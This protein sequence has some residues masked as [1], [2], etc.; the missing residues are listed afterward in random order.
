M[1]IA[2]S[3]RPLHPRR[4]RRCSFQVE[5]LED[6]CLLSGGLE[7]SLD[8]ALWH[9]LV[10]DTDQPSAMTGRANPELQAHRSSPA[11][12]RTNSAGGP[13]AAQV[14]ALYRTFLHQKPS[15]AQL[16]QGVAL[17]K[18]D[19]L[20]QLEAQIL[21]SP[22]YFSKRAH[23]KNARF[24][25][26]V[27]QDVLGHALDATHLQQYSTMLAHGASRT[28]VAT[29]ILQLK[30][31]PPQGVTI[32]ID[33]LS[34]GLVTNQNFT[35][36]GHLLGN[37][38]AVNFLSFTTTNAGGQT[39]NPGS[40]PFDS[41]G[42]FHFTTM[43]N[44]VSGSVDQGSQT[45]HV[46]AYDPSSNLIATSVPFPFTFDTQ[47]PQL[48]IQSPA[49]LLTTNTNVAVTG[50]VTDVHSGLAGLQAQ[51]DSGSF[52]NV[53]FDA[54]GNFSFATAL[55]LDGSADGGHTVHLVAADQAGNTSGSDR[56]F[57]LDTLNP[58]VGM[59]PLDLSVATTVGAATQFLYTG[60]DPVQKGVAPGIIDPIRAA[61]LRG[62]VLTRDGT[63]LA[64]VTV[65]VVSHS[66]F[67]ST[68]TRR[69]GMFDMAV[70]GGGLLTVNY[71]RDGS[72]PAQRQVQVPWEDYAWLP[73]VVLIPVDSHFTMIDLSA[74]TPIQVAR[75]SA[76]SDADGTRQATLLFPQ[77][78]QATM[79]LADGTTQPLT[80]L[81]VRATEYTVGATGPDAMPAALPPTSGYTYAVEFS[82]DEAAAAGATN[83]GFD[84]P[85]VSYVDNFLGFPVGGAV[86][87]GYYDRSQSQWVPSQ[88]GRV[89]KILS[90]TGGRADVDVEGS[91]QAAGA[92]TLAALGITDAE[93]QSLAG[94][95]QPGQSLWRVP[96]THFTP[97]DYNWPYGLPDDATPPDQPDPQP[98]RP[99]DNPYKR[100]GCIIGV[101]NQSL[102]ENVGIAGTP[103]GLNY[104]SDRAPGHTAAYTLK[105]PLSGANVPGTLR[106]IHLEIEVAGRRI[107]ENFP[108]QPNQTHTFTWDGKDAY[109]RSLQGAQPIR[110]AV[111]YEYR[112]Q[113]FALAGAAAASFGRA[114]GGGGG[115]G[116]AAEFVAFRNA[117]EIGIRQGWQGLIGAWDSQPQ[118]LGGWGLDV[119]HAYDL[120]GQV[121]YLGDGTRRS[122]EALAPVIT[123]VAGGGSSSDDGGLATQAK[124]S[125]LVGVALGPDGSLYIAGNDDHRV[126]R[127]GP[128]GII[129][130][131]AG[132]GSGGFSG[133]GGPATQAQ[134]AQ[135][136]GV[137]VGPDGSLYISD[138]LSH[139]IRRVGPDGII[140]TVAGNSP[141]PNIFGYSGDGGPATEALLNFPQGVAVGPDNSLYIADFG[142]GVVRRVGPDGII[143]TVAGNG[144]RSDSGDGG[145]ATQA[146]VARPFGVA[147]GADSSLY[148]TTEFHRVRRVGP[149]GIITTVAGDGSSGFSGDGFQ[150]TQAQLFGPVGIAVGPDGSLYVDDSGNGRIR[151]VG[152]DGIITTVAGNGTSAFGGDGGP[153]T[154]APLSNSQGVAVGPDNNLYVGETGNGRVRRVAPALPG[155]SVNDLV[156]PAEDGSELYVFTTSGRHQRTL[157]ALTGA[158][159][160]QFAYDGAGR[161]TQVT[162]A[163][164]NTTTV[165]RD[166][167][168][169]PTAIV[170]PGG[171]RTVLTLDANG[172]LTG[173]TDPAGEATHLVSGAGGLLTTF[174]DARG[175]GRHFGYDDQGRLTRDEDPVDGVKILTRTEQA[176]GYTVAVT[177]GLGMTSTHQVE[178]LATGDQRR[179]DTMADGT[180]STELIRKDG[181]RT[182]TLADGTV[183]QVKL[184]PDPRFGMADPIISSL[185]LTTPGG[186]VSTL[187]QTRTVT[188]SDPNNPLSLTS[189]TD[190]FVVNGAT[191][192]S[193][194][195]AAARTITSR[196]PQE[197]NQ[198]TILDEKGHVASTQVPGVDPVQF[199]YDTHGHL[200]TV[201]Q[202]MRTETLTYNPQGNLVSMTDPLSQTV[203]FAYDL[204]GRVT[205]QTLPDGRQIQFSYDANGN[206]AT[207]TPPG[208]P[209]HAFTYTPV[210]LTQDYTPPDVGTGLTGTHYTYN[211][212]RQ[213]IQVT[214]PDGT[215]VGFGYDSGGN[216]STITE[217]E[218]TETLT[219]DPQTGNLKTMTAPSGEAMAYDYD[220]GLLTGT[221]WS[222]PVSGSVQHTLDAN[223]QV[224][225]ES[226]TGFDPVSF[227][228][229]RDG[230]LTRAGALTLSHDAQNGRLTGS[231]LSNV[232]D[233]LS[234]D[235]FGEVTGYQ[236]TVSGTS[237]FSIQD[238]PDDLGRVSQR[239]E[240]MG[241]VT[242]TYAYTYDPAG[243][244]TAVTKDG[245]LLSQYGY[246]AN[247]NRLSYTGP[248]GT[249]NGTYDSQDRLLQYGTDTYAYRAS[250]ELKSKTDTATN[251][252]TN[253]TYDP[254]GNLLAVTLPDGTHLDYVVDGQN[255]RIGKK[256]NGTLVQCF[257]YDG[258]HL[259]AELDGAGNVVGRFIYGSRSNVPDYMIKGGTTYRIIADQLGS[260]RLV[261]NTTTGQ[262]VQRMDYDEFGN[263]TNETNPGFQPFG[264]A[265]GLYARDTI[266]VR[267]GARDYDAETGRW[268]GKDPIGFAGG[269]A[270][271]YRYA[272]GDPVNSIDFTGLDTISVG[273]GVSYTLIGLAGSGFG[274][275]VVDTSGQVALYYGSGGGTALGAGAAGGVSV[276]WSNGQTYK[277]FGGPFVNGSLSGGLGPSASLDYFADPNN[278]VSGFGLTVGPGVGGGASLLITDTEVIPLFDIGFLGDWAYDAL[279]PDE[280]PS[281][282]S[283]DLCP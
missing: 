194:F 75:G 269:D 161:L 175:A 184:G 180:K 208:R 143:T 223:F 245:A 7:L 141:A 224:V 60:S 72:L 26:A 162:D 128:D 187:S 87:A 209:A 258:A 166:A 192:T 281:R 122:A 270:N 215:T 80:T 213:L 142:N 65:T 277:D 74:S 242:H 123:T 119:Q 239:T 197:R 96:I 259:V 49:S 138:H 229:D 225:S 8:G 89:I 145:L 253:Y 232:T 262:V 111:S 13:Q 15:A 99:L 249:L 199:T 148:I 228:Y 167:D 263:V 34:P 43:L 230:L 157:D 90:V 219:Y 237:L 116:G 195:D 51:V 248:N 14:V 233:A 19:A 2:N 23:R 64:G 170:A 201:T 257:L 158:V 94:L 207:V 200:S 198:V 125:A 35:V 38:A 235:S 153:A 12:R 30:V 1:G 117:Q 108:P 173:I 133:D 67:G 40:V 191:Y 214:R 183:E 266:L 50:R 11:Q 193:R 169:N 27:A 68:L 86:P 46:L 79:T 265:G 24:L 132:N 274:G 98:D 39:S 275:L 271:L 152:T 252:T 66:E 174:T 31:L 93:R 106:R 120:T 73:D 124:L 189:Q 114:G 246:D 283:R 181:T 6:R 62:R 100:C 231:T 83:I 97:W 159:R 240:T 164:G 129:T 156:I 217:P 18:G 177:D 272:V 42:A 221:T 41:T 25:A 104:Q 88:D 234:Y 126:R 45:L 179:V 236:A 127:V 56:S 3:N 28:A 29:L 279:H 188:L 268:T 190:T 17:L 135:P 52:F 140:T 255:R 154:Q 131:V 267:F 227:Q 32:V 76:V 176:D 186:L 105:I 139:R 282:L 149:D 251:Q 4:R 92:T 130:T 250:G 220:G 276:A 48:V 85:V 146:A 202:G 137:A 212:D 260:P 261:V 22:T 238:T 57:T 37:V 165:Q 16:R 81:N 168:G 9:D 216:L 205:Q 21:G 244:L 222:G 136:L 103:F 254:L 91:G 110:V 112:A 241:G 102:G 243:R 151:R 247:G 118:G 121:L 95:Y 206:V 44:T 58:A 69:D 54:S 185:T 78:E 109:G 155:F 71:V 147:V 101:Q 61:A 144:F 171:Q 63:P 218:G 113:Y 163:D 59:P 47:P 5:Q 115:P 203:V 226:V 210:D 280:M 204:A 264:F 84:R 53:A 82:A 160:Y 20:V 70:N 107:V 196:T 182:I 273:V 36:T 55:P 77:G 150:A 172:Y 33:T 256:V 211:T 178:N 134:L 278:P 10:R